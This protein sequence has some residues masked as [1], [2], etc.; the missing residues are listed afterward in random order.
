M[1]AV[2]I[3][4]AVALVV[5][6]IAIAVA[7]VPDQR[8]ELWIALAK[9]GIQLL[10]VIGLGAI[11]GAVVKSAEEARDQRRQRDERRFAIFTQVVSAYHRLK[12]RA[13]QA[14]DG[15]DTRTDR[16]APLGAGRDPS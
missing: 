16:A 2:G 14:P 5:G 8:D 9:A 3:A 4:A 12:I 1:W 15:R 13:P 11:V 6:L 7:A 10:V